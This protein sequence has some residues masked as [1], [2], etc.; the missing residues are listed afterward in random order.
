MTLIGQLL[1]QITDP[2]LTNSERAALRCQLAKQ[3]EDIG[4][5]E[6]AREAMD[7]LWP[8]IGERPVIEEL[9]HT[10][11]AEVLLRV[12]ALTG[13]IGSAKQ[14]EGAQE[15][16]K[17]LISES[18]ASFEVASNANK[19]TEAQIELAVCYWREGAYNEARVLLEEVRSKLDEEDTDLKAVAFLRSAMVEKVSNRLSDALRLHF[20]AAPLFEA[21]SNQ[22]LKGRFHNEY[23]AVLMLLGKLE[24]RSDYVDRA[25]I[26]YA[27]AS[28]HFE[29]ARLI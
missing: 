27:A 22:T 11:A 26:E 13:W 18:I 10:T 3:F 19:K 25:L 7:A 16:A 6:S 15:L 28:Y 9:D 5:Y 23:G 1:H 29:K 17:D 20:E 14:I 8:Q 12:G 4:N 2:A 24:D 21:S